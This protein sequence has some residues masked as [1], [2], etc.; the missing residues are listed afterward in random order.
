MVQHLDLAA[1]L[2][3]LPGNREW[4]DIVLVEAYIQVEHQIFD[5]CRRSFGHRTATVG[6]PWQIASRLGLVT[7]AGHFH[8]QQVWNC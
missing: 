7:P 8:D 2:D 1:L 6:P 3:Q 4:A 5:D